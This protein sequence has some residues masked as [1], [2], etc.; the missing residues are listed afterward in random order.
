MLWLANKLVLLHS[1]N[2]EKNITKYYCLVV[3]H[4]YRSLGGTD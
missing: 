2:Y 3:A 4:G 1:Y